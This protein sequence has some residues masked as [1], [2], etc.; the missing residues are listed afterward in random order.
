MTPVKLI[1]FDIIVTKKTQRTRELPYA[2]AVPSRF[3]S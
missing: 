2:G 3:G 1:N